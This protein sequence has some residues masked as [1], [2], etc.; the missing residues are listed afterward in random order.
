MDKRPSVSFPGR[1]A[2]RRAWHGCAA[3]PAPSGE[4]GPGSAERRKCT[5]PRPGHEMSIQLLAERRPER[6]ARIDADDAEFAREEFQFL[7]R[8]SQALVLGMA[9]DVGIELRGGEFAV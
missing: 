8:K 6:V 1:R 9:V 4:M 5:A 2:T 7:Q 3:E